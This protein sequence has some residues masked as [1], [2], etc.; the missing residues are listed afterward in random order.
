MRVRKVLAYI[1]RGNSLLVFRHRD[2][3]LT[4]VGVQVPAGTVRD[5]EPLGEAVL[6]E[7][8]EETGLEALADASYLGAA[9]Y[10]VRPG[11]PEIHERHFFHMLAPDSTPDAWVWHEEHDGLMEPTAFE[12]FW[13]PLRFGHVL[14]AGMGALL[15]IVPTVD[16]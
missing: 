2:Y 1:T 4:E 8:V 15:S 6:R 5:G 3:P 7:A 13:I 10:D 12:F 11:R 16:E 9:D 14:A